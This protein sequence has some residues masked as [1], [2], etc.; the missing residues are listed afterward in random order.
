MFNTRAKPV[1][2]PSLLFRQE[3]I[4][5]I[6]HLYI[7]RTLAVCVDLPRCIE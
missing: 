2:S 1:S 6:I 3:H 5:D 7:L 4:H